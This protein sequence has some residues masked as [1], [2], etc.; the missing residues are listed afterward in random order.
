MKTFGSIHACLCRYAKDFSL[1]SLAHGDVPRQI[2]RAI[3]E[4]ADDRQ[5]RTSPLSRELVFWLLVAM[6]MHRGKS[7]PDAFASLL[8]DGRG[9]RL[10]L[11]LRPVT[12]GALAHAR[13][14]L[15]PLPFQAFFERMAERV[16]PP[17]SLHGLAVWAL[18]GTRI[19]LADRPANEETFGRPE[20]SARSGYPQMH[21]LTLTCTRTHMVR[22]AT[23]CRVPPDERGAVRELISYLGPNDLVLMDRGLYAAWLLEEIRRRGAH[24]LVRVPSGVQPIILRER[25]PGDYDVR[26]RVKGRR[27]RGERGKRCIEFEARMITYTVN[28]ESYRLL[29]SLTDPAITKEE[30]AHLYCDRW[31]IEL[32]FGELKCRLSPPPP[33]GAPTHFRGRSPEMVLQEL[34]ATLATYNLVRQ[35]MAR[36]AERAGVPARQIS[37]TKA[38]EVIRCSAASI[39]D[40][41]LERLAYLFERLI[42]DLA[43][44]ALKRPRRPRAA[45]R[46]TKRRK[47]RHP[48]KKPH[49]R[50][51]VRPPVKI[52]WQS[53]PPQAA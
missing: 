43:A 6:A 21:V 3:H 38:L 23:W 16:Q 8:A 29:T 37:F 9:R 1:S 39:A 32:A 53:L 42:D 28:G 52:A 15:G 11:P 18:D 34:W 40:A 13:R 41:P 4:A 19:N 48:P 45:P 33:A 47:L 30:L 10:G 49:H 46:T 50:C 51:Q 5:W 12:D 24:F 27:R 31:E 14:R 35:L 2:R 17:P 7:I 36:G 20:G 44:C 25:S 26:I 22:A